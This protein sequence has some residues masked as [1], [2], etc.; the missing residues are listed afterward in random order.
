MTELLKDKEIGMR[1]I[2]RSTQFGNQWVLK[3]H[4]GEYTRRES[5]G[6]YREWFY[7]KIENDEQFRQDVDKLKG[8]KLY[9]PGCDDPDIECCHGHVILEYLGEIDDS[10]I[11]NYLQGMVWI[12]ATTEKTIFD[13]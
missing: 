9:C 7:N 2:G 1:K 3:E 13:Y 4:G 10:C 5:I 12:D 6:K 11:D 8:E